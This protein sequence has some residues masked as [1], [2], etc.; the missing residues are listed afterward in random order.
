ME[1]NEA[2]DA[3]IKLCDETPGACGLTFDIKVTCYV[4]EPICWSV[5]LAGNIVVRVT[6]FFIRILQPSIKGA[7]TNGISQHDY[8][9]Q[10]GVTE[11]LH[12]QE[13]ICLSE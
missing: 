6:P 5:N 2:I 8:E 11:A 1:L 9:E 3:V 12:Q 4:A 13:G 7:N 10:N